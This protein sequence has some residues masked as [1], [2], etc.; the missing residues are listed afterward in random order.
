MFLFNK[1][2]LYSGSSIKESARIREILNTLGIPY[3]IRV[4][5]RLGQWTG[6]GT[7]RSHIGSA[8]ADLENDRQ[9]FIYVKKTDYE[10]ARQ[11]IRA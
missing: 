7:L 11:L 10:K 3:T 4:S 6:R 9:T 8:G 2:E 1:C 5:S